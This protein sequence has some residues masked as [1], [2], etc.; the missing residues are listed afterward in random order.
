MARVSM[1]GMGPT[2]PGATAWYEMKPARRVDKKPAMHCSRGFEE[3]DEDLTV[4][5]IRRFRPQ[6]VP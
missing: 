3:K 6:F 2:A 5:Y 1:M 4:H